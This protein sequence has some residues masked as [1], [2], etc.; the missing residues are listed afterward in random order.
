MNDERWWHS[1]DRF[2][3]SYC[4]RKDKYQCLPLGIETSLV[5]SFLFDDGVHPRTVVARAVQA[6]EGY[7]PLHRLRRQHRRLHYLR[8]KATTSKAWNN[9]KRQIRTCI[10]W[11]H[12]EEEQQC[13]IP[14]FRPYSPLYLWL[15]FMRGWLIRPRHKNKRIKWIRQMRDVVKAV[16]QWP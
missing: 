8:T 7:H 3:T 16:R 11:H 12:R 14:S 10:K 1:V 4:C 2:K 13:P 6:H 15:P 9:S 5:E